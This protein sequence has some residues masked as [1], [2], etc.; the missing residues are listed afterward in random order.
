MEKVL[1]NRKFY[2]AIDGL[3]AFSF[4]IV[5]FFHSSVPGFNIGWGGVTI[6]FVISGFLITR[7]SKFN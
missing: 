4:L 5:F 2:P 7:I 1:N 6:F 3:R